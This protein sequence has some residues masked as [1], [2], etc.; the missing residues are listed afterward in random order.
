MKCLPSWHQG[1]HPF[2]SSKRAPDLEGPHAPGTMGAC[3]SCFCCPICTACGTACS[4]PCATCCDYGGL[5]WLERD[6]T[7][8]LSLASLLLGLC[9]H[10]VMTVKC[11]ALHDTSWSPLPTH[12]ENGPC[13]GSGGDN[14]YANH[15][16]FGA[17]FMGVGFPFTACCLYARATKAR[18]RE[19]RRMLGL[20]EPVT[21]WWGFTHSF[22]RVYYTMPMAPVVPGGLAMG[23]AGSALY[24]HAPFGGASPPSPR[25]PDEVPL[26][27]V[28]VDLEPAVDDRATAPPIESMD[29]SGGGAPRTPRTHAVSDA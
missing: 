28:V 6:S 16:L 14:A 21:Y 29:A 25:R 3:C 20:A 15:G 11:A 17:V 8:A 27:A 23:G 22:R 10:L 9:L 5:A 7:L 12:Y 24:P 2:A 1:R 18:H 13:F 4:V 19:Q 26:A